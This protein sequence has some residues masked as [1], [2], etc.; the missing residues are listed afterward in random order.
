VDTNESSKNELIK[1]IKDL[2]QE[3]EERDE[4]LQKESSYDLDTPF[5]NKN[6]ILKRLDEEVKRAIRYNISLSITLLQIDNFD[7]LKENEVKNATKKFSELIIKV[8]REVDII[9]RFKNDSFL[10]IFPNSNL[11][12]SYIAS[13]RIRK[14]SANTDFKTEA[15]LSISGGLKELKKEENAT[16]IIEEAKKLLLTAIEN[17]GNMIANYTI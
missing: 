3:R 7:K 16:T 9:G 12:S 13:D 11:N 4:L 6:G 10:I 8:L 1:S 5:L 15:K 14:V 17:G 2:K